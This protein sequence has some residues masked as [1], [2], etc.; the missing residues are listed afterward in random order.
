[1]GNAQATVSFTAPQSNGG[2][3]IQYYS[4]VAT[5]PTEPIVATYSCVATPLASPPGC[6]ILGLQNGSVYSFQVFALNV[7]GTGAGSNVSATYIPATNPD[8]VTGLATVPG[9]TTLAVSWVPPESLGGGTFTSYQVFIRERGTTFS[10]TPSAIVG[11][12]N[13]ANPADVTA[14]SYLATGLTNGTTY[15][16]KVVVITTANS[17]AMESNTTIAWGIPAT[18]P[19]GVNSLSVRALGETSA[20]ASWAVPT[21][22]GGS[23]ITSY[24][25][26]TSAGTCA[27]VQGSSTSCIIT[28]LTPGS[29]LSVTVR[30][31]NDR[32]QSEA[33]DA[34]TTLPRTTLSPSTPAPTTTAGDG[35]NT[36]TIGVPPY[37]DAEVSVAKQPK[38]SVDAAPTTGSV[39]EAPRS[40]EAVVLVDGNSVTPVIVINNGS[41]KITV[42]GS[43]SLTM[44]AQ[45]V[46]GEKT[47]VE[48]G[49]QL[50]VEQGSDI[51]LSGTGFQPAS[52]TKA[53]FF[54]SETLLGSGLAT[55]T[56]AVSGKYGVARSAQLGDQAFK[57]SGITADGSEITVAVGLT[58][59]AAAQDSPEANAPSNEVAN[60]QFSTADLLAIS[61]VAFLL[62]LV[63]LVRRRKQSEN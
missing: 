51:V 16:V 50:V 14:T 55:A 31:V 21:S 15:D 26:T 30:A 44:W 37:R 7:A 23:I 34:T 12:A 3:D 2:A 54:N 61:A 39:F 42:P 43:V 35:S 18:V 27:A 4:V 6:T 58:I 13:G 8:A 53:W 28:D 60:Q 52:P 25:V 46:E 45:S 36:S 59:I 47:L 17:T 63:L 33:V 41:A 10:S 22:D 38:L 1:M 24:S 29:Q 5:S 62:F 57:F 20:F 19:A 49:S 48:D 9:N 40:G 56:G 32:G 11:A